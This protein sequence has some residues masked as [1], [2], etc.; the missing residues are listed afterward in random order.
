MHTTMGQEIFKIEVT[1]LRPQLMSLA[2]SILADDMQSEDVV[3]ETMIKL[4]L[5]R[6]RLAEYRSV[7]ALAYVITRHLCYNALRAKRLTTTNT[8][9]A[10][11][12]DPG[13]NPEETMLR[14]E[15]YDRLLLLIDTL[16]DTQRAIMQMKHIEGLEVEEIAQLTGSQP[17]NIRV[18]LSRARKKIRELFLK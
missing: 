3:Q 2:Q 5:M 10:E 8:D 12:P 6:E 18:T 13:G 9:T 17:E 1:P 11:M 4:W 7:K 14:Q 15:E 16:P